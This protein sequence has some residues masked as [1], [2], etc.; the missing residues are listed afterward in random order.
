MRWLRALLFLTLGALALGAFNIGPVAAN[1]LRGTG[2][3]PPSFDAETL[4]WIA[5]VDA[6]S[7]TY[8]SDS[9]TIADGIIVALH[10]KTYNAHIIY[11]LP[12]LG[13]NLA[14]ARMPLRD[15][16][17]VGITTSA[18]F[19]DGDFSQAA[20]LQGNGV[21]K[22]LDTLIKPSQLGSSNNGGMGWIENNVDITG[23]STEPMGCYNNA[24]TQRFVIDL[25]SSVSFC[26]WGSAGNAPNNN[27]AGA[28]NADYYNQR[29]S[30]TDRRFYTDGIQGTNSPNTTSDTA[31]GSGDRNILLMASDESGTI[32]YWKGRCACAYLTDGT[33]SDA[34]VADF[35]ALLGTY[36]LTPTG[37]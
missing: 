31:S 20:G 33:L 34:D 5:G 19:A 14:A 1:R 4:T 28:A 18:G 32:V 37:R 29:I 16:L 7:G 13:S 24:G 6:A 12:L 22:S 17:G 2:G 30:S 23:T 9:K 15:T 36:L 8:E 35:H 26:C 21:S 10:A 11:I 25:R 3:G 27:P